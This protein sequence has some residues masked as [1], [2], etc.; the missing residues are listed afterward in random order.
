VPD[1]TKVNFPKWEIQVISY[2]TGTAD[3]VHVI[4]HRQGSN[5]T[6]VDPA[7]PTDDTAAQAKWDASEWEALGVIMSTA[8]DLHLEIILQHW[9]TGDPVYSL[10]K[11]ICGL[12]HSVDASLRHEAWLE[13]LAL[14]RSPAESYTDFC[15]RIDSG[16]AK[17]KCITLSNQ[18]AVQHGEE[19][20]LF[21]FLSGLPFDD[22]IHQSLTTQSD[23]MLAKATEACVQFNMGQRIHL[24]EADSAN[25][26]RT[27]FC[28]KCDSPDH[29]S[30][31]CPHAGAV[32][33][34]IAKHNTASHSG[35]GCRKYKQHPSTLGSNHNATSTHSATANATSTHSATAH[36]LEESAGVAT[37][38][39]IGS[40]PITDLWICD[41]GTSSS[42]TGC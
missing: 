9:M 35:G 42:M 23:L 40:S 11:K 10:W 12:H 41:S 26:A 14:R 28:W 31:D 24:A 8:S 25:V 6:L 20:C 13:F 30:C 4:E 17:I 1:L 34:L 5:N 21:A 39:L 7:R 29:L 2:L 3:H 19:L 22:H 33:D 16:Y 18:M 15:N 32:K 37:A 36:A 38:F 27:L